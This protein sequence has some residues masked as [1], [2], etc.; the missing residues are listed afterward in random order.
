M[1]KRI[2]SAIASLVVTATLTLP[3]MSAPLF[4]DV[5]DNHWAKDAVAALAAKGLVEG[6]P[7]GT[8]KGDRAATRWEVAMIVARLLAKMEQ[9]HAT[10]ATKAE[11]EELRKLVNALREE[12][13]ALGVRVTNLEENVSRLDKRVSELERITFYGYMEARGTAQSFKTANSRLRNGLTAGA[14]VVNPATLVPGAVFGPVGVN[15]GGAAI[16]GVPANAIGSATGAFLRPE[17]HGVMPAVDLRNG[18]PLT[19]GTGF[20]MRG[21]LG[22]R[23]RVSDDID[24]GAEFSAFTSQGDAL[25]DAYYGV[26][27]PFLNNQ[28]QGNFAAAAAGAT[29][30]SNQP[31]TRMNLDN[32]WVLHNPSQ[33]KLILGSFGE[34]NMDRTMY[35]GTWNPNAFG[36]TYLD[37]YG[38]DVQG[39]VDVSDTGVLR[40]EAMGTRLGDGNISGVVPGNY[41]NWLLGANLGFEFEGGHVKVNFARAAQEQSAGGPLVVGA[42][43]SG[44]LAAAGLAPGFAGV[45]VGGQMLNVPAGGVTI[46]I[47]GIPLAGSAAY[48]GGATWSPLQWVNP[49]GFFVNQLGAG[50]ALTAGP[51]STTD[52]RPVPGWNPALDNSLGMLTGMAG[53]FGPQSQNMYGASAAYTWDIG[54]GDAGIYVSGEYAHTDYK[55]NKNSAFER[56]GDLGH[57]EVGANLLDGDLDLSLGYLT[58][59]PTYDPFVLQ[60]PA[61]VGGAFRIPDLNYFSGLYSLHDTKLYPHNREGFRF[62]GQWR[63]NERRGLAYAHAQFLNQKR[64]SLYDVL[65]PNSSIAALVPT[66]D[67]VG[68]APGWMDPVFMGFAHPNV[69]GAQ[70]ANSFA[71]GSLA[72]LENNRGRQTGWGLGISYK[73]DDPRIKIDLGYEQNDFFRASGLAAGLGGSQ[74]HVDITVQQ[75]HGQIGWEASDQWSLRA[76]ADWS[77]YGGHYDPAGVYNHFAFNTG[78]TTFRNLDT[79]QISPFIGT[80]FDVSANTSWDLDLRFFDTSDNVAAQPLFVGGA[81]APG[82]APVGTN[83]IGT[84]SHPLRWTG[85]QVTTAFKVRF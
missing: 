10:F 66:N 34:T 46:P 59:D 21:V 81:V 22:L 30:L 11:L 80:T 4:P 14:V 45:A 73:F 43:G 65:I 28:F 76:G 6:Y 68:F 49:A 8:F 25:V 83:N 5:P 19:N 69:Y 15:Y 31:F 39:R 56:G 42:T 84:T 9:E 58:V 16:A 33:T 50:S 36:N 24:A 38:F 12:L 77:A 55:S 85:Y 61:G 20:T 2:Q 3:A 70:S 75:L 54:D 71:P 27:A 82:A 17:V 1:N 62:N 41:Q 72:P 7:D 29:G 40:W 74:N 63:F 79:E 26:T 64:T 35:V 44:G 18:R 37:S 52:T 67:V 32:F 13:D 78:S 57:L 51:G 23:I 60:Y 47:G 48:S 53:A